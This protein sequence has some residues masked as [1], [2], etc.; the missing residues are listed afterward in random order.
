MALTTALA[1]VVLVSL[2]VKEIITPHAFALCCVVVM[3][4]ATGTWFLL[5]RSANEVTEDGCPMNSPHIQARGKSKGFIVTGIA[6]FLAFSLWV[7]RG[8]P[9]LPR[10]IG[11]CFLIALLIGNLLRKA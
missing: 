6:V 7:T 11:T 9:W 8:G 1:M 4:V 2:V 5:L 10:L 3:T